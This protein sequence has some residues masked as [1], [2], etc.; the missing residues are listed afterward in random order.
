MKTYK[1]EYVY[2]QCDASNHIKGKVEASSYREA[3]EA[4]LSEHGVFPAEVSVKTGLMDATQQRFSD[5]VEGAM[6]D[7]ER[8]KQQTRE[9][10]RS[11]TAEEAKAADEAQ[12]SL[13][14]TDILLK[15]LIE[16][17]DETNQWLRKIRWSLVSIFI[18]IML[19]H[20]F[21]WRIIPIR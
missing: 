21:G 13:S 10:Y 17:Q 8:K 3:Y 1:C 5:H 12:S 2:G 18:I 19:W 6:A 9:A 16:K 15:Q 11:K 7:A 4:F 20:L 14:S